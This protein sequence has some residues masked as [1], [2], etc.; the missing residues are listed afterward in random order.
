MAKNFT[1]NICYLWSRRI[2]MTF[3]KTQN[4]GAKKVFT[5]MA[6]LG[7]VGNAW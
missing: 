6:E 3:S 2:H 1:M 4:K 5:F 7:M